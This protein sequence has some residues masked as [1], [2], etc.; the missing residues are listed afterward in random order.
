MERIT[1]PALLSRVWSAR[2]ESLARAFA[3]IIGHDATEVVEL[4]CGRGQLTIPLAK[5]IPSSRIV[6]VDGFKG[7]YRGWKQRFKTALEH[8]G[9]QDRVRIVAAD[10]WRWFKNEPPSHRNVVLSS[11]LLPEFDSAELRRFMLEA[12][13]VLNPRGLVISSFL[14]PHGRNPRQRLFIEADSEPRWTK[15]S[16]KEWFSPPPELVK[17]ELRRARFTKIRVCI[18]PTRVRFAG[19]AAAKSLRAWGVKPTFLR[20]YGRRLKEDGLESPNWIIVAATKP[21]DSQSS[22]HR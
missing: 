13:R 1:D 4:G 8:A 14:S 15:Y 16:P 20:T 19:K 21:A 5:L 6:A 22:T 2:Y 9:L 10:C 11:E 17:R 7:P 18:V 3:E 12:H